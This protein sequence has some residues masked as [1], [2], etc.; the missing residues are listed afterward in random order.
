MAK[1]K[2]T[3]KAAKPAEEKTPEQLKEQLFETQESVEKLTKENLELYQKL[4]T[5]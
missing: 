3:S 5:V 4:S 2:D 1:A